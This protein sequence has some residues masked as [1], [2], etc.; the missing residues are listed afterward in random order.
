[1][2]VVQMV[3]SKETD[4]ALWQNKTLD[5]CREYK[6]GL[7]HL[8]SQFPSLAALAIEEKELMGA[9]C[10]A[11][12]CTALEA[13]KELAASLA[14]DRARLTKQRSELARH[15][16]TLLEETR[17]KIAELKSNTQRTQHSID[18]ESSAEASEAAAHNE[19]RASLTEALEALRANSAE[20][21]RVE[22]ELEF[23]EKQNDA[24]Q[25]KLLSLKEYIASQHT[26]AAHLLEAARTK[27]INLLVETIANWETKLETTSN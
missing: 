24:W 16:A 1:M 3:L 15:R 6:Q 2:V 5:S 13:L 23:W 9:E 26:E 22:G 18:E 19:Q 7:I 8:S 10:A 27:R 20:Y 12:V 14:G 4:L 25:S 21:K 17:A 11:H